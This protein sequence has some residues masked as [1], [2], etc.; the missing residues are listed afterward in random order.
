MN[1]IASAAVSIYIPCLEQMAI[2]LGTTNSM[3]QMTIVTH[4]IGE[5]LGRF[6]CGP[7]IDAYSSRKILIP[8]LALSI[9]GHIVCFLSNSVD[10]FLMSRFVQALGS[11]VVYVASVGIINTEFSEHEKSSV[12]GILEL[13]QPTAWI[14]SPF[15]GCILCKI[16]SWRSSILLLMIAQLVVLIKLL[17]HHKTK[18]YGFFK[19]M[20]VLKFFRD[21]RSVLQNSY[22]VI[23]AIIPGLFAGGYMIFASNAPFIC[24]KF[25]GNRLTYIALFQAI[26][27]VFYLLATFA[28]RAIVQNFSIKMAKRSGIAVYV[29]FGFYAIWLTLEN[30]TLVPSH[31]LALMCIQCV[32]SAFLVPISILKAI[33]SS[34]HAACAGASAVIVFRNIIMSLCISIGARFSENTTMIM[35]SVFMTVSTVLVLITA[36]RIMKIRG[37]RKKYNETRVK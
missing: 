22:F 2:D 37:I 36:R 8:A 4:L 15:I 35:G 34:A 5:F 17:E 11:S 12:I 27:L 16:G 10:I 23:Y 25:F 13:Y 3:M 31:M 26:P 29:L 33:Q 14:L 6:L 9:V 1:V 7:L 18:D 21:Y 24:S 20:S 32:G 28:Y 30:T 19:N